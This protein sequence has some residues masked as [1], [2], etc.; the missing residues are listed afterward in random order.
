MNAAAKTLPLV[1]ALSLAS[2]P[3]FAADGILIV[4]KRTSGGAT[5][6]SQVQIEKTRMRAEMPG[7]AGLAQVVVFD[8]AAQVMRMIDTTNNTYTEMTKADVD[9]TANQMSGAMAQMQERMKSL[10][11][12]QRAQMEA[13]LRGRGVGGAAPATTKTEYRKTGTD[14]VGKWTC[15]KYDGY[16]GEKKVSEICTV[17]PGVLGVTPGD[18]EITKQLAAFFQRL[19]PASA[20]QLLTIGSPE[21]GFSG[22]PV[23]SHIIGTRDTTIEITEVTRKVFGDDTFSVPA[24]FQK[25]A[26]PF[27]ARGRQQ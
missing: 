12:E 2:A 6:T 25:R 24:G 13:V 17:E 5:Q 3:L 22:I 15:Q 8:G 4:E 1:V 9:R 19:S 18:F 14:H 27:G 21:L 23:R 16:Q 10:P 20:N 26:S 11:P 7:P